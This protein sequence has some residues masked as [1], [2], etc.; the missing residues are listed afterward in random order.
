MRTEA[1][2][3]A[4]VELVC[5]LAGEIVRKFGRVRMRVTGT[6]MVPSILPGDTIAVDR[7]GLQDISVGDVVLFSQCGR[8]Y[9]HRVVRAGSPEYSGASAD[10]ALITR[11]DRLGYDDAPV[12][13]SALLGRVVSIE[14]GK[15]QIDPRS[16]SANRLL[17]RLLQA[18]D[19]VTYLYVRSTAARRMAIA[20]RSKCR[21]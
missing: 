19:R 9:V 17:V 16:R 14:R 2:A 6:S 1:Q 3:N 8:L 10:P 20:R 21:A 5:G 15:S 13:A 12:N 4:T 18:S 11:G 7:A